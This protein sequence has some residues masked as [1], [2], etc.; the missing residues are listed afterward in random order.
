MR[1]A[2]MSEEH[3]YLKLEVTRTQSTEIYLM[4]PKGWRPTR[5][6]RAMIGR[7]ARITT[8]DSDWDNDPME[9]CVSVEGCKLIAEA[10][11]AFEVFDAVAHL[12][13]AAA[14]EIIPNE[15]KTA[16]HPFNEA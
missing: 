13:K 8:Y 9:E 12:A 16:H 14:E 1:F 15:V 4:V 7:A 6:D 10:P 11:C 5:E 2:R 3:E